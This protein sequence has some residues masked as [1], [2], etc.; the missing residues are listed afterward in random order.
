MT[1]RIQTMENC[2]FQIAILSKNRDSIVRLK[3]MNYRESMSNERDPI[4]FRSIV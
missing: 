2:E 3:C 4:H 1:V